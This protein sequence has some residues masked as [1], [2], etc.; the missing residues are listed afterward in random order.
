MA[1]CNPGCT[2]MEVVGVGGVTDDY[3][4]GGW[5][6]RAL[7]EEQGSRGGVGGCAIGCVIWDV[8]GSGVCL[9]KLKSFR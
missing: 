2:V 5:F 3:D 4:G 8:G 9:E 6:G 1:R 7:D